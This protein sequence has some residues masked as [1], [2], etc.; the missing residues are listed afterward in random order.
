M[1]RDLPLVL[2]KLKLK[3]EDTLILDIGCGKSVDDAELVK[4]G[5]NVIALDFAE[6]ACRFQR[7]RGVKA[8][9]ADARELPFRDEIFDIVI[10]SHVLEHFPNPWI[11]TEWMRVLKNGGWL[12]ISGPC[13]IRCDTYCDEH[14]WNFDYGSITQFLFNF[15]DIVVSI[16]SHR[17][18]ELIAAVRK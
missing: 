17:Q 14:F 11:V 9:C 13:G 5:A 12:I 7:E 1:K 18:D 6:T 4:M 10:A 3:V 2:R 15:S 8:V 16:K